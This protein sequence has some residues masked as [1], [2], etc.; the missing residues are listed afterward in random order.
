MSYA[1]SV[2]KKKIDKIIDGELDCPVSEV[3][4][5]A[6]QKYSDNK[7]SADEYN[8]ICTLIEVSLC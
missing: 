3:E 8:D 4:A 7:L 5:E 2:L 6:Y 1:F